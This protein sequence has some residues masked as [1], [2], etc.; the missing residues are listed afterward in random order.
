MNDPHLSLHSL[1]LGVGQTRFFSVDGFLFL[2]PHGGQA[3]CVRGSLR[4]PISEGYFLVVSNSGANPVTLEEAREFRA[5]WFTVRLD[6]MFPL[7]GTTEIALLRRVAEAFLQPR[8]YPIHAGLAKECSEWLRQR[9]PVSGLECRS[10]L[11]CVV[12]EVLAQDFEKI[13]GEWGAGSWAEQNFLRTFEDLTVDDLQKSDIA[14]L[15]TKFHCGRRHLNRQFQRYLGVSVTE[16]RKEARLMK[17]FCLLR[18]P[19]IKIMSVAEQC[20]FNHLGLFNA[21]FR[22]RFG[23]S[24]SQVRRGLLAVEAPGQVCERLWGASSTE[25]VVRAG[26][27]P[28]GS[29]FLAGSE[30]SRALGAT[31]ENGAPATEAGQVRPARTGSGQPLPDL[32][33]DWVYRRARELMKA[34]GATAGGRDP[35]T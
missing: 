7:F 29:A 2:M 13:R 25:A 33:R 14:A 9:P 15:A 1:E 3:T 24:P 30:E 6:Q 11:L 20:G 12:A 5:G 32:T 27:S 35:G 23:G 10:R 28:D 19:V 31:P 18:D 8:R 22:A 21:A 34:N 4:T 16:L 17:A 26:L